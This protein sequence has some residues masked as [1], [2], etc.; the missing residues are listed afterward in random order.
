M[1]G[2][3]RV[4]ASGVED[5]EPFWRAKP[6]DQMSPSQWESLCDGCGLCCLVKLE[7]EDTGTVHYTDVGCT[8]LDG[9]A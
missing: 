1:S 6:L 8:L 3:S 4:K 5:G 9:A 2:R 7:D